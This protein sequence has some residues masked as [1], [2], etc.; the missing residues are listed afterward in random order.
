MRRIRSK[1]VALMAGALAAAAIVAGCGGGDDDTGDAAASGGTCDGQVEAGTN[2]T[3]Q[4]HQGAE[5]EVKAVQ[6]MVADFNASQSDVKAELKLVPEAD[7]ATS[8]A[9]QADSD[10]VP[11]VVDTDASKAFRYAWSE[12]L[13]PITN[14]I[15]EAVKSDLLP[16][17]VR[18]GTYA[19]QTWAVGMFDSGLGMYTTKSALRKAGLTAP[20]L[21][22]P[23]TA[24]EFTDALKKFKAAGFSK[25]LDL[26]KNYGQGEW[27][28][29]G[30]API[31]W[32]SGGN[33]L[34]E[35]NSTAEGQL[36]APSVVQGL[37]TFQSWF[38]DGLVGDNADDTDFV[39][40]TAAVSWVGHWMYNPYKEKFGNDLVV[41]PLPDF[42][43]G[44]KTGQGSWQWGVGAGTAD[45][46]AAWRFIEFTLQPEQQ[47]AIAA[48]S[49]GIPARTSVADADPKFAE[50][51]DLRLFVDQHAS[52]VSV[53][54]P[55]TPAYDTVSN[56]FNQAIQ[57]I[58]DGADVKGSLDKA[59]ETIDQDIE[60]NG[61][62]P[63]P[64]T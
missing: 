63:D 1:R 46:D 33:L 22:D 17:I 57:D 58:I 56:A 36:N 15:P 62:Y 9:G 31:V 13:Q 32:S 10:S 37:T 43:S 30:F 55:T 18:Q 49:G 47:K 5:A 53:P 16:S 26:K 11:D 14:C 52:G 19:G 60:D 4:W 51:G 50:G 59:V 29:Y 34:S 2:I 3:V 41:V 8:L 7:Y 20:T 42:G 6:K 39:S 35:D 21:D 38:K 25:P 54:R 48:A 44:V 28:A 27:Y 40:G 45:P 64:G 23:W 24:A 61:G 12:D